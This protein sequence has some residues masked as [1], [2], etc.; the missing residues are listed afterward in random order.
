MIKIRRQYDNEEIKV[1]V[2]SGDVGDDNNEENSGSDT[3]SGRV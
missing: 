3:N 2:M 1:E